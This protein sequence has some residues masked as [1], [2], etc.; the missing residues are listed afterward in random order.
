MAT[1]SRALPRWLR[2]PEPGLGREAGLALA[3]LLAAWLSL[4]LGPLALALRESGPAALLALNGLGPLDLMAL[5]A[6]LEALRR[7]AQAGDLH[8]PSWAGALCAGLLLLPSTLVAALALVLMGT[9]VAWYSR[10]AA[11]W[12]AIGMA[13]L[14]AIPL[15]GALGQEALSALT[16]LEAWATHALLSGLEPGLT[17]AGAVLRMPD[18]HG[19]AV[20]AGCSIAHFLPPAVL[21]LLVMRRA[22][23]AGRPLLR[24]LLALVVILVVLN[25]LRLMLLT[26]S[27]LAYGWGH[28][29]LG[30]NLFGL[31]CV[32]VLQA[33]ADA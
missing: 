15:G 22:E 12:G 9:A 20:L 24:P 17:L 16:H 25:L 27:P 33:S 18:G 19:I 32:A 14:G 29:V 23:G 8:A 7:G 26:W 5:L 6:S 1:A 4:Q 31:L 13:G 3:L 30:T 10:G 2:I 21:A 28:G 11:R